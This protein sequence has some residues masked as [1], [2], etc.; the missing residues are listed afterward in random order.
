MVDR[1]ERHSL[2][3]RRRLDG[4]GSRR[5]RVCPGALDR[6]VCSRLRRPTH[7]AGASTPQV[8][9]RGGANPVARCVTRRSPRKE[10]TM[11]RW[12][13][14]FFRRP[15]QLLF[16]ALVLV[17]GW[18]LIGGTRRPQWWWPLERPGPAGPPAPAAATAAPPPPRRLAR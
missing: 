3:D 5:G 11:R 8:A 12:Q 17:V 15:T 13:M 2:R 1:A 18:L 14:W 7:R 6:R 4:V 16:W 9:C 10:L